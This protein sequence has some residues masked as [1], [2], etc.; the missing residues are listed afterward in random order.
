MDVS[1]RY[2]TVDF[3]VVKT[4]TNLDTLLGLHDLHELGVVNKADSVTY[5]V[6][7]QYTDVFEGLGRLP[8]K[9]A[10]QLKE[11]AQPVIQSARRVPFRLR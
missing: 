5:R 6:A 7:K 4:A 9:H 2:H 11:N 3:I 8:S 10:L 1:N